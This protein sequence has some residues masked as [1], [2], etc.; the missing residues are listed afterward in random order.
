MVTATFGCVCV[1]LCVAVR[2]VAVSNSMRAMFNF[3]DRDMC[4]RVSSVFVCVCRTCA[5]FFVRLF[6]AILFDYHF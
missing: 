5:A 4:L 6:A 3:S 2:L 1:V